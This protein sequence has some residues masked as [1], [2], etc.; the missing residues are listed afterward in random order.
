MLHHKL[1][2]TRLVVSDYGLETFTNHYTAVQQYP[3]DKGLQ[4]DWLAVLLTLLLP[5]E[6]RT[7]LLMRRPR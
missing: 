2:E 1:F 5:L 7:K 3:V 6:E 4:A